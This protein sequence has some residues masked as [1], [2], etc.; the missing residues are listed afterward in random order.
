MRLFIL[1]CIAFAIV[2]GSFINQMYPRVEYYRDG[3]DPGD[4]LYLT[5]LIESG[6]LQKVSK[7]RNTHINR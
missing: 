5:P 4:P 2:D 3:D 7:L 1:A 6:D